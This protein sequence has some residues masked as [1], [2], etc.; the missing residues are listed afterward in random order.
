M[1][2]NKTKNKTF[3]CIV[4]D[5]EDKCVNAKNQ[6]TTSYLMLNGSSDIMGN[7]EGQVFF[8]GTPCNPDSFYYRVLP[9]SGPYPNHEINIYL[10]KNDENQNKIPVTKIKTDLNGNFKTL[11]TPAKI[12]NIHKSRK[13]LI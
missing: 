13:I 6:N 9:C 11:L 12:F 3:S 4:I 8:R 10:D 7:L 1:V 2:N 5:K